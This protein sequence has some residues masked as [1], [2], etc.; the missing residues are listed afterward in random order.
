MPNY[1]HLTPFKRCVLQNF[2]FIEADFDALTNYGLLCKVVDYLNKVI[3][4]QNEVQNNMVIVN[5][6]FI[7]LRDQFIELKSFVESY[8]DNL[9]V[10]D[11]VNQKLDEMAESGELSEAIQLALSYANYQKSIFG[12]RIINGQTTKVAC[13]G[14]SLTWCQ[15]PGDTSTQLT[16]WSSMIEDF[17]NSW[18]GINGLLTCYNYGVKGQ[19]SSYANEHFS[20]YLENSPNVIFWAYGTNDMTQNVTV[21]QFLANLKTF[22][23]HCI[24]NNIELI[25]IISPP[26]FQTYARR[27]KMLNLA[28]AERA[29]CKKYGIRYVDMFEYV[30]NLYTSQAYAHNILQSDNTHFYDYTCYRDAIISE[31]LTLTF[32]QDSKTIDYIDVGESRDYF[33]CNGN[34]I[35]VAGGINMFNRGWRMR[36]EA[37]AETQFSINIQLNKKSKVYLLTYGNI[38]AGKCDYSI[39][40]DTAVTINTQL[41]GSSA[42]TVNKEYCEY[43]QIGGVMN[44]G[45]HQIVFNNFDYSETTGKG[46]IYVF[47]FIIE[48]INDIMIDS[49]RLSQLRQQLQLW[50]GNVTSLS[51]VDL[52]QDVNKFNRILVEFG[53]TSTQ[54]ISY[55][56]I[57]PHNPHLN[58]D[59]DSDNTEIPY[60]IAIPTSAGIIQG[61]ITI[62]HV[63]N[64]LSF[65]SDGTVY[66]RRIIGFLDNNTKNY[67]SQTQFEIADGGTLQ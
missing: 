13:V 60:H 53:N 31:L 50:S 15:K 64:T 34:A 3:D 45:L 56:E 35:T 44:A 14:D 17:V 36:Q 46:R 65:T 7:S 5:E 48:E 55:A 33:H 22:Y 67:N 2:P 41:V 49:T 1:K 18:R 8:F 39:D 25:V 23:G 27:N 4:S 63:N 20:E 11:E 12:E 10:Q 32:N 29:F 24:D 40:G 30:D 21:D 61:T 26:S 9:D 54:G 19:V 59:S 58:F 38:T 28:R 52:T 47:G 42:S 16:T 51:D 57:Y 37:P 66:I 6:A 43:I 62:D